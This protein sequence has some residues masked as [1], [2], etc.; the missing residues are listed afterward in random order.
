MSDNKGWKEILQ[1]V[2]LVSQIGIVMLSNIGLGFFGGY[3]LDE[4][5]SFEFIFKALGLI[6]GIAAGFYSN[7][8]IITGIFADD[9]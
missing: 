1:A 2:G 4:L 6:I 5:L 9:E 8:R 3:L 7:Y